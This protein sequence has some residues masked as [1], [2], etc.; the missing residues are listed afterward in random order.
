M[1][2]LVCMGTRPE[3][4]KVAPVAQALQQHALLSQSESP[5]IATVAVS[6]SLTLIDQ[7]TDWLVRVNVG[8]SAALEASP[9]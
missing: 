3:I 5:G 7:G 8:T 4:I 9:L 1:T 6:G 2:L